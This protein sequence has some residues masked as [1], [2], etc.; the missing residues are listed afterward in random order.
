MYKTDTGGPL[1][2]L[3]NING[4]LSYVQHGIASFSLEKGALGVPGIH[5]HVSQHMTWILKQLENSIIDD[6]FS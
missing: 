4:K 2:R 6:I 5:T 1:Q 3:E